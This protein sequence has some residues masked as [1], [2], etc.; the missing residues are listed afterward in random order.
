MLYHGLIRERNARQVMNIVITDWALD[1]YLDLK[2]KSVFDGFTFRD[3]IR[4]DVLRL[5]HFPHGDPKF[6][7]NG[8]WSIATDKAGNR[9]PDGFKMKWHNIGA[10][11]VQL[12]LP[13][14]IYNDQAFL[15]E[16]YVKRNANYEF[17]KL[18]K[19]KNHAASIR[20]N[21]YVLKGGL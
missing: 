20:G 13:V 9:I 7:H 2:H 5:R 19:F 1:S 21:S 4:P 3:V 15:G 10:G 14:L 18:A 17:A 16:A 12:R 6:D 8:F 11:R